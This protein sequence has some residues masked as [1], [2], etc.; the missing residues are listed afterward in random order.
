MMDNKINGFFEFDGE[1]V[2]Y[3][4]VILDKEDSEDEVIYT[5]EVSFNGVTFE[6]EYCPD[7]DCSCYYCGSVFDD[8]QDTEGY[9]EEEAF[10]YQGFNYITLKNDNL[11]DYE[12][13][14]AWNMLDCLIDNVRFEML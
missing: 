9:K 14:R 10:F 3:E 4:L 6:M 8:F 13:S 12:K 7:D 5:L 2:D 1:L 11:S